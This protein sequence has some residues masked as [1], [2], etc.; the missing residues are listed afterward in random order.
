DQVLLSNVDGARAATTHLLDAG[1]TR[2]G[3]I[4]GRSTPQGHED[5]LS[6][7]AQGYRRALEDRAL[8]L[9]PSAVL[10]AP[11]TFA[12]GRPPPMSC[13]RSIPAR[14]ASSAPPTCSRS[15]P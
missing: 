1:C 8:P 5:V 10:P 13:S 11:Y 14:T 15:A 9:V 2:P 4:G 12:G 3:M 6:V 7:R